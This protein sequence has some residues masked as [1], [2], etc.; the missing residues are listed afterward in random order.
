MP[1]P[2][3]DRQSVGERKVVAHEGDVEVRLARIDLDLYGIVVG[4]LAF[5]ARD[6]H[7]SMNCRQ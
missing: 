5:S 6:A 1:V 7:V 2:V 4:A 3:E